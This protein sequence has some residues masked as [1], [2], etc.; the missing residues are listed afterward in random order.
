[1]V[2]GLATRASNP[3]R[4]TRHPLCALASRDLKPHTLVG[5]F[6]GAVCT[7][8]ELAAAEAHCGAPSHH[9]FLLPTL[10][11]GPG[12]PTLPTTLVLQAGPPPPQEGPAAATSKA[13]LRAAWP[14]GVAC[15]NDPRPQRGAP[16]RLA[17]ALGGCAVRR[18]RARHA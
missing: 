13:A 7:A 6:V 4:G 12:R 16:P 10:G 5:E 11:K 2:R 15:V 9:A 8:E 17:N 1:V 3:V 18:L 14:C